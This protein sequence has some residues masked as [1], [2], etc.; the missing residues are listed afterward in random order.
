M[1]LNFYY[2]SFSL[3]IILMVSVLYWI[4]QV[5]PHL[6]IN[7]LIILALII[8]SLNEQCPNVKGSLNLQDLTFLFLSYHIQIMLIIIIYNPSW[9]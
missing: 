6:I 4:T 7:I 2:F 1:K 5:I 9:I 8:F 3:I